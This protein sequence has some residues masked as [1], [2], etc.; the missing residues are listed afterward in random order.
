MAEN[1]PWLIEATSSPL[2]CELFHTAPNFM[3]AGFLK[4]SN[5]G[6]SLL[7]SSL[8]QSKV[9]IMGVTFYHLCHILL[10]EAS[11]RFS[12]HSKDNN[13]CGT[14]GQRPFASF[15]S[16]VRSPQLSLTCSSDF[17]YFFTSV[18]GSWGNICF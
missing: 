13:G 16:S 14:K 11:H 5:R 10:F 4:T 18:F 1:H 7:E 17:F 2:Q 6:S 3:A 15:N 9:T 8:I 12:L